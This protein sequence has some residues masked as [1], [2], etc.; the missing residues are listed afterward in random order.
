MQNPTEVEIFQGYRIEA[1]ENALEAQKGETLKAQKEL[2][3]AKEELHHLRMIMLR[4][5]K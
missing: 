1:L 5:N 2:I 3:D 4:N